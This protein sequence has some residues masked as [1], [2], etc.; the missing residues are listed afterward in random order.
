MKTCS[1]SQIILYHIPKDRIQRT[2]LLWAPRGQ[3][4]QSR[5]TSM[6]TSETMSL[7]H[8]LPHP[9]LSI[10]THTHTHTPCP[11]ECTCSAKP[12]VVSRSAK[13]LSL[14]RV[15]ATVWIHNGSWY[16][17]LHSSFHGFLCVMVQNEVTKNASVLKS[18]GLHKPLRSR[19]SW[20]KKRRIYVLAESDAAS[21]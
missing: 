6:N 18:I 3:R 10:H 4:P 1:F 20:K 14:R 21:L 19:M 9:I 5:T 12:F 8:S 16:L 7:I 13:S 15:S 2:E 17:A 11:T